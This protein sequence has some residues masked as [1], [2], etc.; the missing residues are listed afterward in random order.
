MKVE[1]LSLLSLS[2][3]VGCWCSFKTSCPSRCKLKFKEAYETY[4][5][6]ECD[7]STCIFES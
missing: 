7:A 1:L 6:I 5:M 4:K 3:V 2:V